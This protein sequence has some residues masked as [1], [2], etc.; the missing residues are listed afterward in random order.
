MKFA[1][2]SVVDNHGD[3]TEDYIFWRR[4]NIYPGVWKYKYRIGHNDWYVYD[5]AAQI[6]KELDTRSPKHKLIRLLQG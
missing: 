4:F 6:G 3:V 5:H 1:P 2:R